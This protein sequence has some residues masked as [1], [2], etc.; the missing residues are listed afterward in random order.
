MTKRGTVFRDKESKNE[1]YFIF[2][3]CIRHVVYGMA[4]EMDGD[5]KLTEGVRYFRKNFTEESFQKV[6]HIDLDELVI[7]AVLDATRKHRIENMIDT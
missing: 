6:G 7:E 2:E 3:R 1:R 4:V 5:W